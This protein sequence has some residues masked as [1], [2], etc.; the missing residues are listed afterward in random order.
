MSI[1]VAIYRKNDDVLG[2]ELYVSDIDIDSYREKYK[3]NLYCPTNNCKAKLV[4]VQTKPAQFRTWKLDDHISGCDYEFVR[5][6]IKAGRSAE[7][8]NVEMKDEQRRR[9]LKEALELARMS[10][11]QV[12]DMRAKRKKSRN[13]SSPKT[14]SDSSGP[15]INIVTVNGIDENEISGVSF[16][17]RPVLKR[18]VDVLKE[19]DNGKHRCVTG[20]VD[21]V[22]EDGKKVIISVSRKKKQLKVVFEEAFRANSPNFE[23]LFHHITK[24]IVKHKD[25]IFIGIGEV[26]LSQDRSH[27]ELQVFQGDDFTI[28]G[29]NLLGLVAYNAHEE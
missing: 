15:K 21:E 10:E 7:E 27:Y 6:G 9:V 24:Y 20:Y 19:T 25:V 14:H 8:V 18:D 1:P 17:S 3:T 5:Q 23:G 13:N 2:E 12:E 11:Q 26:R 16:R 28:N 29:M 22:S 4:F